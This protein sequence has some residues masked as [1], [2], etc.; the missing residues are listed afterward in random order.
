MKVKAASVLMCMILML[1]LFPLSASAQSDSNSKKVRVG[2][3]ESAFNRTDSSKRRTG[4]AYEYQRKIASYTGWTYEY[5]EGSWAQ[6]MQKLCDGEIDLM[7]GVTYTEER[8]KKMLFP[9]YEMGSEEYY[10]YISANNVQNFEQDYSYFNGKKIGANKGAVQID[11]FKEWEK[12][13]NI[14]TEIVELTTSEDE[15]VEML[16]NGELDGYI[17][18]DNSSYTD[19][20]VPVAKVGY[21][22]IYFAV[23]KTRPD[24][25]ADL[26]GALQSIQDENRFYNNNL[27]AKYV[28]QEGSHLFLNREE[29]NW[30]SS[31]G[32]IRVGYLDDYLAFCAKDKLTGS[33]TGALKDFL[34]EASGCFVNAKIEF[35]TTAYPNMEKA[36]RGLKS[37][38]VDCIFPANFSIYDGEQKNILL[39]PELTQSTLYTLIRSDDERSFTP[40]DKITT[41]IEKDNLNYDSILKDFYP[42]WKSIESKNIR[43]AL[44]AVSDGKA[45]CLLISSYRYNNLSKLCEKYHLIALDTGN[46]ISF[47]IAVNESDTQLYAILDKIVNIIPETTINMALTQY[48]SDDRETSVSL[49]DFAR[50]HM[51]LVIVI[52]VVIVAMLMMIIFQRR[53]IVARQ[54]ASKQRQLADDL[55]KR[56]YVDALTAVRNKGGYT[57]YVRGL[58]EQVKNGEVTQFAISMFDCDDLKY[59]NDKYGHDKGDEYLKTAARLICRTFRH[60]PVFRL[61]GDEFCAI[62]ISDDYN[63]AE[64]LESEFEKNSEELNSSVE[65]EWERSYISMGTAWYDPEIDSSVDDTAS[66]ADRIMYENKRKRKAGRTVR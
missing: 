35:E 64:R 53:L 12:K 50:E 14:K 42:K 54:N 48:F 61:G 58:Q 41:V 44:K 11:F 15:S 13:R 3:F 39:T 63:N 47:S 43:K 65:N 2:W 22:E 62:L 26:N 40:E 55:S 24:L 51:P 57:D 59:I 32:S 7:S 60:S 56:V 33:L 25:L 16:K 52:V 28:K 37:G 30:L 29:K 5:V 46:D 21:S 10:L 38:E 27:F 31:H 1:T 36:M 9:E 20:M 49:L 19:V 18:L 34:D 4:Y 23:S 66:R 6:L 17:T 8:S 45:D